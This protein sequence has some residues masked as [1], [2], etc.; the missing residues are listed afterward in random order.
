LDLPGVDGALSL[1]DALSPV[2]RFLHPGYLS[3]YPEVTDDEETNEDGANG[4]DY[5]F[6]DTRREWVDWLRDRV[7]VNVVPRVLDGSVSADFLE[8]ASALEGHELLISLRAWW[9]RLGPR[10][11]RVGARSLGGI[12]IAGRRLDTLY[13]RR[14]ALAR[15]GEVLELP[16]IPVDDP[17]D[18]GWDFLELLGVAT[19]MNAS[20]FVNKLVHMQARGEKDNGLVEY[21][22]KQLDARFEEDE[23]LIK[24]VFHLYQLEAV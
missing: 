17:E 18:H 8:G 7:G 15:V 4:V 20:F 24:C 9:P 21:I 16:Y 14:G 12:S 1:R 3:A 5:G 6:R 23:M 13:L 19:R 2:A 22:Y 10:L 11:S